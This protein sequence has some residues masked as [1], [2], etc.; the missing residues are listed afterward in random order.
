MSERRLSARQIKAHSA[1]VQADEKMVDAR[2][3]YDRAKDVLLMAIDE[4]DEADAEAMQE[5]A[6]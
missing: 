6:G 5:A 1:K 3:A 4:R 2:E